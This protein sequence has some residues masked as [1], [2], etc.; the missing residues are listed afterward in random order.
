MRC[1]PRAPR[2]PGGTPTALVG[3]RVHGDACVTAFVQKTDHEVKTNGPYLEGG[4]F[5]PPAGH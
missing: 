5:E 1:L 3:I 4:C 2:T